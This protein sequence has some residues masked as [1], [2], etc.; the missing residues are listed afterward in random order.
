MCVCVG[1]CLCKWNILTKSVIL[2]WKGVLLVCVETS[3]GEL[4]DIVVVFGVFER[5]QVFLSICEEAF[6]VGVVV[7]GDECV[8]V[9][10]KLCM[11]CIGEGRTGP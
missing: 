1:V 11:L 2:S 7:G 4:M 8:V 10:C 5:V 3:L 6:R 9:F